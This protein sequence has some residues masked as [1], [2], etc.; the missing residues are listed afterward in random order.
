MALIPLSRAQRYKHYSLYVV[1]FCC[2]CMQTTG[3]CYPEFSP[4]SPRKSTKIILVPVSP[5]SAQPG[6]LGIASLSVPLSLIASAYHW[7][8]S[9][10][11][12]NLVQ[13]CSCDP[14][15]SNPSEVHVFFWDTETKMLSTFYLR[16]GNRAPGTVGSYLGIRREAT[17]QNA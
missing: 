10:W 17:L 7:S 13:E 8:S 14:N 5:S 15:Q 9:P 4:P 6:W 11:P 2:C 1:E 12:R 3:I 16:W